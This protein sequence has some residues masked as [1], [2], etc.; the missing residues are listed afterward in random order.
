MSAQDIK[1]SAYNSAAIDAAIESASRSV[2]GLLHR[3]FYPWTGTRYFDYPSNQSARYWR[4]WLGRY[5][6]V[7]LTSIANNDGSTV[8]GANVFLEPQDGPPYDRIEINTGTTAAWASGTTWQRAVAVTGVYGY[9]NTESQIG[10]TVEA[11]DTT[12]TGVDGSTM[13]LVGVGTILRVD[14]E[15]MIVTGKSW[16]T[17]AQTGSL[18]SLASN[19]TLTVV[20][21]SGFLPGETLLIDS[22]RVLVVDVSGNTLTVKRAVDGSVLA[23]HTTAT[24]YA[25]RSL[26]VQRGALGT[27]AATHLINAPAYA[28]QVPGTVRQLCIA[29]AVNNLLQNQGGY[30]RTVGGNDLNVGANTVTGIGDGI[31][32]IE[33]AAL[34]AYGRRMRTAAV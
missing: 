9:D 15:R 27:T 19:V 31:T 14:D 17:T 16:L 12:E 29:Y 26:T 6:L 33:R 1:A 10:T 30:T 22:E 8:S 11:L 3:T 24:I 2:E 23:T 18:G 32:S 5:E 13:P 34:I 4:L 7:S 20:D 25:P 21:G 28:Y